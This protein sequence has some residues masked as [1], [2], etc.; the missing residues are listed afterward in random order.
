[1]ALG[2]KNYR[3][4]LEKLCRG[5]EVAFGEGVLLSLALFGS[6]ARREAKPESDL[7]LLAIH[8]PV[9]FDPIKRFV[10][11]LLG[12]RKE[13]EY[14]R[15]L[16]KGI[17]PEPIVIFMTPEE[18]SQEPLIL[19]DIMDH[20]I[21]LLDREGFLQDK[22]R[23]LREKLKDLGAKKISFNDGSWAWDLKP[24]WKPGELIEIV[25]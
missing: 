3:V 25:L 10:D 18:L 13:K 20:G 14:Q 5:I 6:V 17:Y 15:L 4:F 7:D 22:I 24:D 21:I 9:D 23:K 11:V 1:M 16:N 12:L 2:Y 8:K 19:L